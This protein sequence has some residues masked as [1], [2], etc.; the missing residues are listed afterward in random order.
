[1][2]EIIIIE[3]GAVDIAWQTGAAP[4]IKC[5][6]SSLH[7]Q[8]TQGPPQPR[9]DVITSLL[10]KELWRSFHGKTNE[11]IVTKN[12]RLVLSRNNMTHSF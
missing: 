8:Q 7:Q 6:S 1:M 10:D 11:M 4:S 9:E 2:S 12:G 3:M 5:D